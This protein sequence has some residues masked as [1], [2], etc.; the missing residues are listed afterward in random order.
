MAKIIPR[1]FRIMAGSSPAR[2]VVA[3]SADAKRSW[4]SDVPVMIAFEGGARVRPA[5]LRRVPD[6][7]S[8]VRYVSGGM[9]LHSL[10]AR[11]RHV[12]M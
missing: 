3:W 1:I 8:F 2:S 11:A 12:I 9:H 5:G 6:L 7:G 4:C 10:S